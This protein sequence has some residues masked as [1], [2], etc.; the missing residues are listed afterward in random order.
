M[1][2]YDMSPRDLGNGL[3][4]FFQ[5]STKDPT[6]VRCI[7]REAA[8]ETFV[9]SEAHQIT[10]VQH[11]ESQAMDRA[12]RKRYPKPEP[13]PGFGMDDFEEDEEEDEEDEY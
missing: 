1:P 9:T 7:V 8:G 12:T 5:R 10:A 6:A 3:K 2:E 4:L 11:A 13:P